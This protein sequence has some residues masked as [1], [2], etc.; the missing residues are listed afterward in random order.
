MFPA[1]FLHLQE[2]RLFQLKGGDRL[3]GR[4]NAQTRAFPSLVVLP[5]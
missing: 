4:R 5:L 1:A 3:L 2:L